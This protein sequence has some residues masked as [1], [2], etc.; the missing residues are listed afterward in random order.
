MSSFCGWD[1]L[2]EFTTSNLSVTRVFSLLTFC[3]PGPLLR[4][5]VKSSSSSGMDK[6]SVTFSIR[7]A[8]I[9]AMNQ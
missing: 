7:S 8:A 2:G 9:S 5:A 6:N 4:E 1:K 3:P